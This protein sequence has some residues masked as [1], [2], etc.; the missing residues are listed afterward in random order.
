MNAMGH[1]EKIVVVAA[2]DKALNQAMLTYFGLF[3]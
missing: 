2:S 3:S 1:I